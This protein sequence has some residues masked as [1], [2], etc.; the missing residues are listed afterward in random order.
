VA[1]LA[2]LV[3]LVSGS[4]FTAAAGAR[5][6]A[7]VLDR[8][9][10]TVGEPE[11]VI[12]VVQPRVASD[13]DRIL[14]LGAE[15]EAL[16]SVRDAFGVQN[17]FAGAALEADFDLATGPDDRYLS[18]FSQLMVDGRMPTLD[19][20]GEVALNEAAADALGLG[21]GDLLVTPTY[22]I[23]TAQAL[24]EGRLADPVADG[25]ELEFEV[26]GVYRDSGS[27]EVNGGTPQ[28]VVSPDT[29]AYL[30][31]AAAFN[32]LFVVSGNEGGIDVDA[33][34]TV[35]N[36]AV[37][38]GWVYKAEPEVTNQPLR[39]AFDAIAAGLGLF[40][41]VA[42]VAGLIALGQVISRQV[43]QIAPNFT[44]TNALGMRDRAIALAAALPSTLAAIC[45]VMIGA[46]IAVALSPRFPISEARRAEIDPGVRVDWPVLVG[47]SVL[48]VVVTAA[49][50][51]GSGWRQVRRQVATEA[52]S[53]APRSP[54][55]G[56]RRA[57][58]VAAGV[59]C[60]SVLT[61]QSG[62][63]GVKPGSAIIGSVLGI[64]GV[65]TILVFLIS[66]RAVADDPARFG[67]NWDSQPDL[68]AEDP[69]PVVQ[70]LADDDRIAAVGGAFCDSAVVNESV[71]SVCALNVVSGSL[72]LTYLDGRAPNSP[73][74]VAVGEHTMAIEQIEIGDVI[75]AT[76]D[77][78][79]TRALEVVGTAIQP[80]ELAPGEGLVMTEQGFAELADDEFQQ[81]LI[82]RYAPGGDAA[83][84]EEALADDYP[85][86]FGPYAHPRPPQSLSQLERVRPTLVALAAFLGLLGVVGLVHFLLLS[87][88][89]RRRDAAV[90][91]T[92]GFV[93]RQTRAVVAWQA[94]TISLIG[95][96]VGIPFG[97]ILGRSIWVAAIDQVGIV[98][99]PTMPWLIGILVIGVA[100]VGAV[101]V[102]LLPGTVTSRRLPAEALR[103]E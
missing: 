58:P 48:F 32:S 91:E 37:P 79:T 51:L 33:A 13:G 46:V 67:W 74:E 9:L 88:N 66:Q 42:L 57:L 95:V 63:T 27:F 49:W 97:V 36:E 20:T 59:G 62:R 78:G 65:I 30:G 41:A 94:L 92:M 99:H 24:F 3:A 23:D 16:P 72:A 86:E 100:L 96:V 10:D 1:L 76:G 19:S 101:A 83:A 21:V 7:T 80:D 90:L 103:T 11:L 31:D 35:V 81:F 71:M 60:G 25:P 89:R 8:F 5:R 26:V 40:A 98:D 68:Y 64:A 102:S 85:L 73:D 4:V 12:G 82:L 45:G 53:S 22:S 55:T 15:L 6:T 87:A 34:F 70:A 93:R 44:V 56:L 84:V 75:E 61:P 17:L 52:T 29:A 14:A 28:G 2:L 39:T 69:W 77:S 18:D 54:L 50:A 47:G 43:A 38:D